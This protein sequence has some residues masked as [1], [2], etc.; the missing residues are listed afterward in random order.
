MTSERLTPVTPLT[1]LFVPGDRPRALSGALRAGADVVIVDLEDAVAPAGKAAARSAI[2]ELLGTPPEVPVYVRVNGIDNPHSREDI[3]ALAPL[4][5]L[6][7]IMLPKTSSGGTVRTALRWSDAATGSA[8]GG[9]PL[10]CLLEC[11]QGIENAMA[12]AT[13]DPR[14]AGIGLGEIDLMADL[15]VT[16]DAGLVWAR[17]RIVVAARAAGLPP[18][19]QGVYPDVHDLAGLAQ[20][21]AAGRATGFFGRYAI[22]PRQLPV[23][24]D[25]YRP[26]VDELARA[27]EALAALGSGSGAAAL[28]DGRFVDEAVLRSARAAVALA[29]R[30]GTQGR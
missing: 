13:A 30:Y 2:R 26:S 19:P 15:G 10:H 7:G 6:A 29:E 22:H 1:W 4:P 28:P 14:V 12:I 18:P 11:A 16:D 17:G 5:G 23:I 27:R 25:S 20:S 8:G 21:C 3:D 9:P 24:V